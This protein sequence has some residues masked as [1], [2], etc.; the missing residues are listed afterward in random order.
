MSLQDTVTFERRSCKGLVCVDCFVT[1][2]VWTA[3]TQYYFNDLLWYMMGV[4][5]RLVISQ[6]F[7][8]ENRIETKD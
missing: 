1:H 4:R 5:N 3:C 2:G 6:G 8:D 7:A